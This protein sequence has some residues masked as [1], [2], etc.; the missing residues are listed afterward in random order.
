MEEGFIDV[1]QAVVSND[2]MPEVS[3]PCIGSFDLP[4]FAIASEWASILSWL[5]HSVCLV[6]HDQLD[7]PLLQASAQ[8]I[9]VISLVGNQ[10]LRF[11]P[12]VAAVVAVGDADRGEGDFGEFDFR[13]RGRSQVLSQ[14][15]I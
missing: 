4:A 6:G 2:Q 5:T 11:L 10:S 3:Q 13:R 8:R 14:R 1:Q 12:W 9:A 15:K 7:A